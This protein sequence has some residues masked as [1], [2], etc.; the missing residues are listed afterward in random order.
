MQNLCAQLVNAHFRQRGMSPRGNEMGARD[1][2]VVRR[3]P[4]RHAVRHAPSEPF[5]GTNQST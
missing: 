5:L 2:S 3:W 4:P 1:R